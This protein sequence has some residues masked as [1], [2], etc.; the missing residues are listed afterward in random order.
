M[1]EARYTALSDTSVRV[2]GARWVKGPYTVKLE[3][4]RVAGYQTTLMATLRNRRY[5]DNAQ[6]WAD[7]LL[8]FLNCKIAAG[9]DLPAEDYTIDLRLIGINSALGALEAQKGNPV[10][11]GAFVIVTAP[12]QEDATE[13]AKLINPF[14]LHYPLTEDEELPTFAFPY[15]PAHSE[16]GAL[17]EFAMNH[18][19][20]LES[21]MQGF[22][23]TLD[24]V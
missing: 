19:L 9:M 18:V 15:S 17:F 6:L 22:R 21:P 2:E 8:G 1:T 16:R 20:R 11:V 13:I 24:E 12:S 4:A 10:E 5:V 23:L 14:L 7:K 3:A